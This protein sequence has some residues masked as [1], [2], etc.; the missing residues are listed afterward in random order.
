MPHLQS[1][2]PTHNAL[3]AALYHDKTSSVQAHAGQT[4]TL[5]EVCQPASGEEY[6]SPDAPRFIHHFHE[7]Q[8]LSIQEQTEGARTR[9][10]LEM[11]QNTIS[12]AELRDLE[13]NNP[14]LLAREGAMEFLLTGK[15]K[16]GLSDDLE[17]EWKKLMWQKVPEAPMQVNKPRGR[18]SQ[19]KRAPRN[20]KRVLP[21]K[22]KMPPVQ[23]RRIRYVE[24]STGSDTEVDE[25]METRAR[26]APIRGERA[27]A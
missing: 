2:F 13:G 27:K 19:K 14:W 17:E 12:Q 15:G 16:I 9:L 6:Q 18:K 3:I 5:I 22:A 23:E 8:R 21:K 4:D 1:T 25:E 24:C 11:Q 20:Q 7:L 10:F 26:K